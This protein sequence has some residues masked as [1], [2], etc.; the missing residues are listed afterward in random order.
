MDGYGTAMTGFHLITKYI[1][2]WF[3]SNNV[4]YSYFIS[5][6]DLKAVEPVPPAQMAAD[7]IMRKSKIVDA[8]ERNVRR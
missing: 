3:A 4:E 1:G 7:E 2:G 5:Y 8:R 6:C